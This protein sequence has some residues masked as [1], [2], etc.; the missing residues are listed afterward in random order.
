MKAR[1]ERFRQPATVLARA[2]AGQAVEPWVPGFRLTQ[3]AEWFSTSAGRLIAVVGNHESARDVDAILGF[4]LG[5]MG[6]VTADLVLPTGKEAT[7]LRRLRFLTY[8]IRVWTHKDG[9]VAEMIV[10]TREEVLSYYDDDLA[11]VDHDLE[12]SVDWIA[13]LV[14]WADAELTPTHRPSYLSWH[15][16]GRKVLEVQRTG[17]MIN[18]VAGTQY[19]DAADRDLPMPIRIQVETH[20]SELQE[21]QLKDAIER[22]I[23]DRQSRL[24]DANMEHRFQA[25]LAASPQSLGYQLVRREVPAK[26]AGRG[27]IDFLATSETDQLIVVETKRG[28]DSQLVLQGLDY[29]LWATAHNERDADLANAFGVSPKEPVQIDFVL[30]ARVHPIV[31]PYTAAQAEA[32]DGSIS[33]RFRAVHWEGH[34]NPTVEDLGRRKP[35]GPGAPKP[36]D[37]P[38]QRSPRY[39]WAIARHLEEHAPG[40]LARGVFL[41]DPVDGVVPAAQ[42]VWRELEE[43]GLLHKYA[44][45]IRSSQVFAVNLFGPLD[46]DGTASL[47]RRWFDDIHTAEVPILE[48]S[49]PLDRLGET[50]GSFDHQ[51]QVDV[52]LRGTDAEGRRVAALIEAKFTEDDYGSCAAYESA[53]DSYRTVCLQPGPFGGDP[54]ACWSITNKG[55]GGR[56]TYDELLGDK[57]PFDGA[58]CSYRTGGYQPMRNL[59]QAQALLQSGECEA[60]VFAV[61]APRARDD[62]RIGL[63]RFSTTLPNLSI[64]WLDAEEVLAHHDHPDVDQLALRYDLRTDSA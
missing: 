13:S 22:A 53:P 47:L 43:R 61:C 3:K 51:T 21:Q 14:A 32:L 34:G 11:L 42:H 2:V 17:S 29:W 7:T 49:D 55:T 37:A 10:P 20:L 9:D 8:P 45:H 6:D 4:V 46:R 58:G 30:D 26:R 24:D 54:A 28:R 48:W 5:V 40:P 16:Q 62:L 39:R 23:V 52:L 33:W 36:F 41:R 15:C 19:K 12:D 57:A 35:P 27:Y 56:R 63:E 31:S 59:A 18:V 50:S 25:A 44:N 38:R 60:V 1:R 64:D